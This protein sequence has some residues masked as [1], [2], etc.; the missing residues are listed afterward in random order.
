MYSF[1]HSFPLA[2]VRAQLLLTFSALCGKQILWAWKISSRPP[3][4]RAQHWLQLEVHP[5]SRRSISYIQLTM[6]AKTQRC[7]WL[8]HNIPPSLAYLLLPIYRHLMLDSIVLIMLL[9]RFTQQTF[10]HLLKMKRCT[11]GLFQKDVCKPWTLL[12]AASSAWNSWLKMLTV[13]CRKY[14]RCANDLI[15]YN[16]H[17]HCF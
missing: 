17:R 5:C 6:P 11:V 10:L 9:F 2:E 1:L 14:S 3:W 13:C 16:Q 7:P 15:I 12:R 4:S 8:S